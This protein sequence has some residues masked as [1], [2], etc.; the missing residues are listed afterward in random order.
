MKILQS[1][2]PTRQSTRTKKPSGYV[3]RL[4]SREGL[5]DGSPALPGSFGVDDSGEL[6]PFIE[7]HTLSLSPIFGIVHNWGVNE[8]W[9]GSETWTDAGVSFIYTVASLCFLLNRTRGGRWKR[10]WSAGAA[11]PWTRTTGMDRALRAGSLDGC[12]SHAE[13][14]MREARGIA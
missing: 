5:A 12:D 10:T 7:S 1:T 2:Q 6:A 4:A 13:S 14:E 3:R 8:C 11:T 9:T